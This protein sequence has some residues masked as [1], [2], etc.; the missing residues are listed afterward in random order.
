[1]H[2]AAGN[3]SEFHPNAFSSTGGFGGLIVSDNE[4][5][6]SVM[7]AECFFF[8]NKLLIVLTK[9]CNT[10]LENNYLPVII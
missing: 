7:I 1:M 8:L 9:L 2:V 6:T 3:R 4:I 10:Q 5:E